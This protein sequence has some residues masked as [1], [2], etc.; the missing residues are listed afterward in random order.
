MKPI[1]RKDN[2]QFIV[3]KQISGNLLNWE[4]LLQEYLK[5]YLIGRLT[6]YFSTEFKV[7]WCNG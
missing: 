6:L 2:G 3:V 4:E 1:H 5:N 7:P